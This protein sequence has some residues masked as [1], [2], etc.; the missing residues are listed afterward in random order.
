MY[1]EEIMDHY[2]RPRNT[3]IIEG[4]MEA[5]GENSSCGDKTKI[6]VKLENDKIKE[7]KHETDACAICTASIS[8]LSQKLDQ[9]TKEEIANLENSWMIEQL[10]IEISPMREKCATLGISTL[11]QALDQG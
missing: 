11:K 7:I 6:Y 3:G 9:K 8:I 10:G 5:E 4:G 2:K 1:K